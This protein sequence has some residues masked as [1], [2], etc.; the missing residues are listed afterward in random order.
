MKQLQTPAS[1]NPSIARSNI[2]VLA[3]T[4]SGAQKSRPPLRLNALGSLILGACLLLPLTS[5]ALH[6]KEISVQENQSKY[7]PYT[8][9]MKLPEG[10]F[11]PM[12]GYTHADL[13]AAAQVRVEAYLKTH[14]VDPTLARESLIALATHMNEK[15]EREGVE[16]QVSSWYQKPYD[17]PQARAR[18]V[19]AMSEEYG[20]AAVE[21]ASESLA[22]SPLLHEGR[23][24]YKGYIGAAGEA[25]R[26]VIITLNNQG[27]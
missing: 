13:I 25:V 12:Q 21:A 24:F 6:A 11:P 20:S 27:A 14:A 23:E 7:Q 3:V 2:R 8:P 17:D 1:V 10:V 22:G 15:F 18:S 26:D 19:K 5:S 4:S 16:Y 9:G